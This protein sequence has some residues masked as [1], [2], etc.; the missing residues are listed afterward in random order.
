MYLKVVIN[1]IISRFFVYNYFELFLQASQLGAAYTYGCIP[2]PGGRTRYC[3][4][5]LRTRFD[6]IDTV[7]RFS[8]IL[9]YILSS[10]G[11]Q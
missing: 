5:A 8:L 7:K 2:R 4:D 1:R 11:L 6:S 9:F 3:V 10:I